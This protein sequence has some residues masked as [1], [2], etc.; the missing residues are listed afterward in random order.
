M[1]SWSGADL[2]PAG[3]AGSCWGVFVLIGV[4]AAVQIA[5]LPRCPNGHCFGNSPKPAEAARVTITP[6]P[7]AHNVDPV[8]HVAVKADAGTLI[9]VR[10][11]N[12]AGKHDRGRHDPG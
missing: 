1:F 6:G 9:D 11:V 7:D 8:A 5:S 2:V 10:M 12:D 4:V 3:L